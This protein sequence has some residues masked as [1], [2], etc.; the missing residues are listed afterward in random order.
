[1]CKS[2]AKFKGI[3]QTDS[4]KIYKCVILDILQYSLDFKDE[5]K[6]DIC[7]YTI[8]TIIILEIIPQ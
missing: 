7:R 3:D 8:Q 2:Y 6:V 1:M 5:E 4:I